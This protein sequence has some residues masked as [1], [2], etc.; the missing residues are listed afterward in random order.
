M[1]NEGHE[2]CFCKERISTQDEIHSH[3][4]VCASKTDQCPQCHKF[5]LR[6]IFA[7]HIDNN[8]INPDLFDNPV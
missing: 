8:C 1:S 6:S 4:E 2:C 5:I 7:Y 3:L